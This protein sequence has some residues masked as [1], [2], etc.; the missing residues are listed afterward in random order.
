MRTKITKHNAELHFWW[1]MVALNT[2]SLMINLAVFSILG[3]VISSAL[4]TVFGYLIY[5]QYNP[6]ISDTVEE[7]VKV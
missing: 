7:K 2:V 1:F 6:K 5:R 3:I 4:L